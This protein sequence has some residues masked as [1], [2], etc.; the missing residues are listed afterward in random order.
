MDGA[1]DQPADAQ[2]HD[3]GHP[4]E[5]ELAAPGATVSPASTLLWVSGRRRLC[6]VVC[7][8]Y[9]RKLA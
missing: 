3:D 5:G 6:T 7:A 1:A 8:E 2:G 4:A 9:A